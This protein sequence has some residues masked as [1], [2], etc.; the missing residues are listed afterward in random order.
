MN[1]LVKICGLASGEDVR[2][3]GAMGPDCL[4]FIF[5]PRSP[6][7]VT[8]EQ[9]ADWTRGLPGGVR[10]VGVFVD[11]PLDEV[12]ESAERAGLDVIQLHGREDAAYLRALNRPVW[13][14]LHLDR[15]PAEP[16]ALPAEAFLIDSGTVEM[17]GGSGVRVDTERAAAFVAAHAKRKVLLAGGLKAGTVADAVLAV[18]PRGV[19]VSSG[20]ELAPGRKDLAAVREFI[21]NARAAFAQL[22]GRNDL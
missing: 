3:V 13:K 19:D 18:R 5:W 10:K 14:A 15:L 7:A 22:S 1:G 9:V 12:R 4:G 17:P 20:V 8:A 6:R 2:A 16:E 11:Q 21:Q